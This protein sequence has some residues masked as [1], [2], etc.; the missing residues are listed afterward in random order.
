[1]DKEPREIPDDETGNPFRDLAYFLQR[2]VSVATLATAIEKNGIYTTDEYGRFGKASEKE[3]AR[4]LSYLATYRGYQQDIDPVTGFPNH[5]DP[6]DL[7][8]GDDTP[9]TSSGWAAEMLPPFRSIGDDDHV[10][11][12]SYWRGQ[13]SLTAEE[14]CILRH[15]HDP[16]DF[17]ADRETIPEGGFKSLGERVANALRYIERNAKG[18]ERSPRKL[19]EWLAWVEA[20]H[21]SVPFYMLADATPAETNRATSKPVSSVVIKTA[22]V[23][24]RRETSDKWWDTRMRDA[25]RYGLLDCRA[26]PGKGKRPSSWYPDS[27][28][29]WLVDKQHLS[30]SKVAAILRRSFSDCPECAEYANSLNPQTGG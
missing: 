28:A 9:F 14:F 21:G 25:A 13:Q 29:G 10:D 18:E 5:M 19:D 1:M 16:R 30:A 8:A 12:W 11:D 4:A 27:V 2:S 7:T 24:P 22:F 17:E 3:K 15:L 6:L 20:L 26:F 23:M